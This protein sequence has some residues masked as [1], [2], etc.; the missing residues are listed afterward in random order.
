MPSQPPLVPEKDVQ[1]AILALLRTKYADGR[2]DRF[3]PARFGRGGRRVKSANAGVADIIGCWRGRY[4]A[5][6]CKRIEGGGGNPDTKKAQTEYA[7]Q[8]GN[9]GGLYILA[10]SIDDVERAMRESFCM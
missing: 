10:R 5:I 8:V 7:V 9:A 4:V 1:K 3:T 6:E 2:W